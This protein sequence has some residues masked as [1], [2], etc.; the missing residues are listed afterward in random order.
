MQEAHE[1]AREKDRADLLKARE[2]WK[3]E[4]NEEVEKQVK[5]MKEVLGQEFEFKVKHLEETYLKKTRKLEEEAVVERDQL[6]RNKEEE[7]K[8]AIANEKARLQAERVRT[9]AQA[10]QE[11]YDEINRTLHQKYMADAKAKL[12]NIS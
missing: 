4:K 1:M 9:H 3:R 12:N 7:L 2:Q 8:A 6:L 11:L 5:R 10:T